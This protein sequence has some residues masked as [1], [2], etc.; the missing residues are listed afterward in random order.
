MTGRRVI[1]AI[2]VVVATI[3]VLGGLL[4][5]KPPIELDCSSQS[6]RL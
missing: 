2:V 3:V 4:V 1:T 5:W 6:D